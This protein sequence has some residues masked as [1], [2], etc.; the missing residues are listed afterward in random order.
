MKTWEWHLRAPKMKLSWKGEGRFPK[1]HYRLV[2]SHIGPRLTFL[3]DA[4]EQSIKLA[5][6]TDWV[7]KE[8][9]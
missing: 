6:Y 5:R 7:T 1:P 2:A 8:R 3:F 4:L 9:L